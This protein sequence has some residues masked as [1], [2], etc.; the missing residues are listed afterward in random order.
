ME[1]WSEKKS[2]NNNLFLQKLGI[3]VPVICGAMYPCSNP[4]LIAAVSE[5]GGIGMVQPL[6]LV[7]A[8]SIPFEE[9]L[10]QIKSLTTKPV[11]LN[12]IVE[13]NI[14][15]YEDRMKNWVD[16]ALTKGVRFFVTALGDPS[17]VIEK[18]KPFGGIVYHDVTERKWAERAVRLGVDGL[19]CVNNR[20]GGHAGNQSAEDLFK[21]LSDF[22]LPLICA[23]G[24]STSDHFIDSLKMGY[25]GVQMGT[26]FIATT[27]CKAHPNYKEAILRASEKDIVLTKRV[28]GVPLSVIRTPY[29]DSVGLEIGPIA[30]FLFR[31]RRTRHWLRFLYNLRSVRAMKKTNLKGLSTKDYYQAG[32]GVEGINEVLGANTILK[33]F[34]TAYEKFLAGE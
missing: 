34:R 8:Y 12:V 27:E 22:G 1:N 21:Q 33:I 6:S 23:G 28:T 30:Q 18:V 24:V 29:V 25:S 19:I 4:E 20:A 14:K 3:E 26:R 10:N 9:G 7:Y 11:G 2:V 5:S 32:K 13:K 16:I 31:F 17:W 15:A